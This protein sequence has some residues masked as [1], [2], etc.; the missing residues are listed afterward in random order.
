MFGLMNLFSRTLGGVIGDLAGVRFGLRGRVLFLGV[1]L[2]LEGFALIAF[3]RMDV[4]VLAIPAM[5][6]FSVFVQM[7]EGATFSVVPFINQRALGSVAGIVGAGGNAGA[8]TA[9]FL[10]KSEAL[11][12]PTAL[13][14]LGTAVT[15]S[16]FLCFAVK[17]D[18]AAETDAR[19]ATEAAL[20]HR[21]QQTLEPATA[22]VG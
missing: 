6:V 10:F 22:S 16:S 11:S 21:Q 4:L 2:A 12:W 9:E 20:A 18:E 8:L 19:L 1:V 3:S 17:F 13:F 14:I 7:S 15:C 5:I